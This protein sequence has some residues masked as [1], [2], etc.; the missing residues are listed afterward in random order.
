MFALRG[1]AV[2]LAFF[3]VQY[4]LLSAAVLVS[5]RWL[6]WLRATPSRV[7]NWLFALRM[8]P[9]AASVFITATI[10]VPSFQI[11]EPRAIDEDTG[12]LP[13]VLGIAALVLIGYGT[14]RAIAAQL[15]VSRFAARWTE[16]ASRM[17]MGEETA[18]LR[19]RDGSPPLT[20][21]GMRK[22]RVFVSETAAAALGH[23]E[24]R[25]AL[26]HERAHVRSWDNLKKLLFRCAP[27]PGLRKLEATWSRA[28]ELAADD[29][30]V[31]NR[32]DALDLATALVKLSRLVPV[33]PLPVCTAGFVT[34]SV[35]GRVAR[36]LAWEEGRARQRGK[37]GGW[38]AIPP[39]GVAAIFC[40]FAAYGP[41]LVFTHEVTEWLVR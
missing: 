37:T 4:S 12:T 34:G 41:A 6:R 27:F 15:D 32:A 16:G 26:R 9:L 24:L 7:A 2:S 40:A 18:T 1:T 29:A 39:V 13:V 38:F 30:A 20:L 33:E 22:P 5:W 23:D 31:E 10:V 36:L 11:L 19:S 21:V 28:A 14:Y 35:G 25:V 17:E 8:L 3:V